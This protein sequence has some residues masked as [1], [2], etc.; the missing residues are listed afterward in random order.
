[1][2]AN[3]QNKEKDITLASQFIINTVDFGSA[4]S[5]EKG[6]VRGTVSNLASMSPGMHTI[7]VQGEGKDGNSLVKR[8]FFNIAGKP[9]A[10]SVYGVYFNIFN[11]KRIGSRP[12]VID[13]EYQGKNYATLSPDENGGIFVQ[14]P[15]A[16]NQEKFEATATSRGTGKIMKVMVN[17]DKTIK[18]E[19]DKLSMLENW[20]QTDNGSDSNDYF[21][22]V[23]GER[24]NN[25][26]IGVFPGEQIHVELGPFKP[27][28]QI[29]IWPNNF[30]IVTS[31]VNGFVDET[32]TMPSLNPG[33]HKIEFTGTSPSGAGVGLE[34]KVVY[35]INHRASESSY[36]VYLTGF[37]PDSGD[38]DAREKVKIKYAG[39][40]FDNIYADDEGGIFFEMPTFGLAQSKIEFTATGQLTGKTIEVVIDNKSDNL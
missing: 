35:P 15:I 6:I 3:D 23:N 29:K 26:P 8:I 13:I 5:D 38:Y 1:L 17:I 36:G 20:S 14:F 27:D 19:T 25:M 28:S 30:G 39:M 34:F 11:P 7:E 18:A 21:V 24:A 9:R 12:E 33:V 4:T 31:N 37:T 2:I 40:E 22:I 10:G 32:I 16:K